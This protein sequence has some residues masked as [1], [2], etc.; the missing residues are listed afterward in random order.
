VH[1]IIASPSPEIASNALLLDGRPFQRTDA[2]EAGVN[3]HEITRLVSVGALRQVI[4]GVY[5]DARV[6]DDLASCAACLRLRLPP[7]AVV[8]RLTAAWPWGVDGRAP[9]QLGPVHVVECA[10]APGRQPVRRP[11][12]RCYVASLTGDACLAPG[13]PATTPVRT[14]ID[15]LRWLAPHMG[16]AV[17]DALASRGLVTPAELLAHIE[18]FPASRG[19]RQARYLAGLVEPRTESFGESWLRLR[20]VDAGFPRPTSQIEVLDRAG[21]CV[22]RHSSGPSASS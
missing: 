5:L 12:V 10:V 7:D 2:D 17:A 11:G 13:I 19:I 14:A 6:P 8:A 16:L 15:V 4:R 18:D 9:D 3:Q 21:R 1:G 20:I 22:Y